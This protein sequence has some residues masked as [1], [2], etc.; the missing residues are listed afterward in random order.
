MAI[1]IC[2]LRSSVPRRVRRPCVWLSVLSA[3]NSSRSLELL[4]AD[5]F[6][7]S[8]K[9]GDFADM[10]Y[11]ERFILAEESDVRCPIKSSAGQMRA[12][13]EKTIHGKNTLGGVLEIVALN[14]PVGLGSFVQWDKRLGAKLAMAVCLCRRSKG[15][16][17]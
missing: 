13:I 3:N 11:E 1:R 5:M 10:P 16:S 7:P 6:H 15:G 4:W 17:R 12:E 2:D 9:S 14:V 8:A